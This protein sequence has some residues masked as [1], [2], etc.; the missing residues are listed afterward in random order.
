MRFDYVKRVDQVKGITRQ[1]S[2]TVQPRVGATYL[3]T[4]DAKNVLRA[5]YARLGEQVMGRDGVTTFGADDTVS[6]RQEYDNN[7][8]GVFETIV[9]SP[10][11]TKALA[12]QQIAPGLIFRTRRFIVG[13]RRQFGWQWPGRGLHQP[14]IQAHVGERRHQRLLPRWTG[15]PLRRFRQSRSKPGN[16]P[17]ADEQHVESAEI[18]GH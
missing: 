9:L 7:L 13:Y 2:W 12:A 11:S 5:S 4:E 3:L 14:R 8:D 18:P 16:G 17:T 1:K 6:L 15:S 10:A